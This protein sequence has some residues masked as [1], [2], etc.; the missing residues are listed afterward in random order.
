MEIQLEGVEMPVGGVNV[1]VGEQNVEGVEQEGL[2]NL[3]V[4][5]VEEEVTLKQLEG[6]QVVVLEW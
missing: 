5:L 6:K 4:V 3:V 2:K 1:S